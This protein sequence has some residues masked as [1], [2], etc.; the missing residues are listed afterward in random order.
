MR[1]YEKMNQMDWDYDIVQKDF[2][3][4]LVFGIYP[5][6]YVKCDDEIW[7]KDI[8]REDIEKAEANWL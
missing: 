6:G 3:N 2:W 5:E 8:W 7:R 1:N 4:A